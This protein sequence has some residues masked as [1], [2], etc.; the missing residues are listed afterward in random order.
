MEPIPNLGLL[1]V[2]AAILTLVVAIWH[3]IVAPR[4]GPFEAAPDGFSWCARSGLFGLQLLLPVWPRRRLR[5]AIVVT[6]AV[7][8]TVG[9]HW[10]PAWRV[11]KAA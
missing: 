6:K 8:I 11:R 7:G 5:L 9:L 4:V 3:P 2:A 1:L 10:A